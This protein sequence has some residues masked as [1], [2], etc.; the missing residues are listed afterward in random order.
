MLAPLP[1]RAWISQKGQALD[2][3]KVN[4]EVYWR[5]ERWGTFGSAFH[6]WL[7]WQFSGGSEGVRSSRGS[8]GKDELQGCL[9]VPPS[10][11][12]GPQ[13]Q[14]IVLNAHVTELLQLGLPLALQKDRTTQKPLVEIQRRLT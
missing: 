11:L 5:K 4:H 7:P 1:P 8:S 2:K 12:Q 3:T 13:T 14:L 10:G 6:G 9:D